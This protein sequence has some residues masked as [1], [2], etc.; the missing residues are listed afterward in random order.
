[1]SD[2]DLNEV[3]KNGSPEKVIVPKKK[4]KLNH[5]R[6]SYAYIASIPS[7]TAEI[8]LKGMIVILY[9][10]A[11]GCRRRTE[12]GGGGAE[13]FLPNSGLSA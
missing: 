8:R 3:I 12:K 13:C 1:M 6:K 11:W 10:S 4:K 9:L 5:S 2:V 7:T